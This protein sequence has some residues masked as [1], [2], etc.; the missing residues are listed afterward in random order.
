MRLQKVKCASIL[1]WLRTTDVIPTG[2]KLGKDEP[3]LTADCLTNEYVN[4]VPSAPTEENIPLKTEIISTDKH[5]STSDDTLTNKTSN[6]SANTNISTTKD[7]VCANS[8]PAVSEGPQK[9]QE[10]TKEDENKHVKETSGTKIPVED[11][12][13]YVK[14]WQAKDGGFTAEYEVHM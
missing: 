3:Q 11:F 2:T 1:F 5:D 9:D 13:A 8:A 12:P 14:T 4:A 10:I 7:P 6:D